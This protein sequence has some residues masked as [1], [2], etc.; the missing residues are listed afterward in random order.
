[1]KNVSVSRRLR[2]SVVQYFV[3]DPVS[4]WTSMVSITSLIGGI[5]LVSLGILGE[6]VGRIY[7]EVKGRP[8]YIISERTWEKKAERDKDREGFPASGMGADCN[9]DKNKPM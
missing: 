2:T 3:S 7:M 6:Y 4:G 1:M 5:Q 9:G 8:R